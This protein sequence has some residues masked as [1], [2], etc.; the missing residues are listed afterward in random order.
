MVEETAKRLTEY[1]MDQAGD[2]LR[3]VVIVDR[4]GMDVRYLREDLQQTY[5]EGTY[6]TVVDSFRLNDPFWSPELESQ[7][8][9]ERRALLHYHERACVIQFPYSESET[10][11]I[12][13]SREAGRNLVGFIESCRE[14][15]QQRV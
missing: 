6:A 5:T 8:V 7:P 13:V 12:S 15:I 10:I 11:L 1:V 9:G 2:E 14:I 3:T 4:D